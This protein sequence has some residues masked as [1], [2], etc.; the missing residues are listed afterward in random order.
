M[1]KHIV[2]W[3]LKDHALGASKQDN[4]E[5]LKALLEALRDTVKEIKYLEVGINAQAAVASGIL[6]PATLAV[7]FANALPCA[8]DVALYS[9]FSS[10]DDLDAYQKHPEHLKVAGF[11]QEVRL[12]R[13]V[14]DYE[15]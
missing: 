7:P 6:P 11:V 9:E 3:R 12:E 15:I 13:H 4:A 5:K 14:V 1:I 8:A 10:W 2:L